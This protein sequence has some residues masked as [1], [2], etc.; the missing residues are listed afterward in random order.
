MHIFVY[1]NT[2][3]SENTRDKRKTNT[4]MTLLLGTLQNPNSQKQ[5]S[6]R[7]ACGEGRGGWRVDRTGDGGQ[8]EQ[9]FRYKIQYTA[10]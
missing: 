9:T 4:V 1:E 2:F 8:K 10:C 6:Q 3:V 5:R 7:G